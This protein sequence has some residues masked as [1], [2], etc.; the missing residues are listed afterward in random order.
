MFSNKLF[1]FSTKFL[2]LQVK[3][4]YSYRIFVI[5]F[6][7]CFLIETQVLCFS[8]LGFFQELFPGRG[9]HLNWRICFP[10]GGRLHFQIVGHQMTGG[11]IIDDGVLNKILG[12]WCTPTMRNPACNHFLL[13]LAPIILSIGQ[14]F[15]VV[16]FEK[17]AIR[18]LHIYL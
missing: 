18:L 16:I 14:C 7:C 12:Q 8:F 15:L 17:I 2:M 9:L 4:S 6:Q 3:N 11:I 10:V 13:L 1:H 5:F